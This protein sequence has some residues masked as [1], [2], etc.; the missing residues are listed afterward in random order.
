MPL[1]EML[2]DDAVLSGVGRTG[3][4][5]KSLF[6]YAVLSGVGRTGSHSKSLFYYAVLSGVARENRQ[7]LQEFILLCCV[8]WRCTGEKAVTP[9]VYHFVHS[10]SKF[11]KGNIMPNCCL[12]ERSYHM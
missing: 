2:F 12:T 8:V 9:R 10:Q 1:S 4:H 3:S 6:Y 11:D 5:S 7:S